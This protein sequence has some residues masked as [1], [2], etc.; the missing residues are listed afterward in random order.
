ML[1]LA[2]SRKFRSDVRRTKKQGK[3]LAKLQALIK[4]LQRQE[5]LPE[6]YKD[7]SLKGNWKG[8]REAHVEPDWLLIYRIEGSLARTGSH[9]AVFE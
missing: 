2:P 3:N 5:P 6:R 8:Y 7:H 9:S 1:A 4:S